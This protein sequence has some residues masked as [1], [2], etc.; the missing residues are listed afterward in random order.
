MIC[1]FMFYTILQRVRCEVELEFLHP[2]VEAR[3]PI[4]KPHPDPPVTIDSNILAKF[5]SFCA[6]A[7]G[8]KRRFRAAGN[9][10][11]KPF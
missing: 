5:N 11:C 3:V 8:E 10:L 2:S 4:Q 9:V 6:S 1:F 7:M